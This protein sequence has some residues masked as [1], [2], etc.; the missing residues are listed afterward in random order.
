[1]IIYTVGNLFYG[2]LR[3]TTEAYIQYDFVIVN[4]EKKEYG[5][6]VTLNFSLVKYFNSRFY[7]SPLIISII[8]SIANYGLENFNVVLNEYVL[9]TDLEDDYTIAKS[10]T[11]S[12]F[13]KINMPII[14]GDNVDIMGFI[15]GDDKNEFNIEISVI[16]IDERDYRV[17]GKAYLSTQEDFNLRRKY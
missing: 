11:K 3:E 13:S 8:G 17:G 6:R 16:I 7:G 1:M 5:I 15:G 14:Y 10:R 9:K 12:M 4:I 2:G